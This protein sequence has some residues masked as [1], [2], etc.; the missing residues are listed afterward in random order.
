M[1]VPSMTALSAI[2]QPR[3]RPVIFRLFRDRLFPGVPYD[4]APQG[5]NETTE[6][7]SVPV[8]EDADEATTASSDAW[9]NIAR[10]IWAVM[11]HSSES[12]I[13]TLATD[14]LQSLLKVDQSEIEQMLW[15]DE[16]TQRTA[17]REQFVA[18]SLTNFADP[19]TWD[20][21]WTDEHGQSWLQQAYTICT[22]FE[23]DNNQE[24]VQAWGFAK[25]NWQLAMELIEDQYVMKFGT[26]GWQAFRS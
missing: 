26:T 7:S 21:T 1:L 14:L 15:N 16:D 17:L 24:I 5:G 9:L 12:E 3:E 10:G 23:D 25:S 6:S 2:G 20:G 13:R 11:M 4:N 22:T 19:G 8:S 18:A